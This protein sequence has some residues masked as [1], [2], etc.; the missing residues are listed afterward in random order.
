MII[1]SP[2][3]N[4]GK[5]HLSFKNLYGLRKLNSTDA[6]NNKIDMPTAEARKKIPKRKQNNPNFSI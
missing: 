4:K 3:I 2:H 5:F 6:V 1:Q